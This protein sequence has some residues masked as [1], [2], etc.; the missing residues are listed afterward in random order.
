MALVTQRNISN[1]S[2]TELFSAVDNPGTISSL[3]IANT[4]DTEATFCN[5]FL[6]DNV[7]SY[8]I[9]K[10]TL[11]PKG[12]TLIV[13]EDAFNLEQVQGLYIKLTGDNSSTSSA[14]VTI[15]K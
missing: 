5:L 13:E 2:T 8:Y 11:I 7:N 4:H 9:L 6:F 3:I 15:K 1:N 10:N 12:T 14:T